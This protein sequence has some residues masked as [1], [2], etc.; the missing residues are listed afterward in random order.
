LPG[1]FF[2]IGVNNNAR[3]IG[4][5]SSSDD[6]NY[7][8]LTTYYL[9][10]KK[11][12]QPMKNRLFIWHRIIAL[13]AAGLFLVGQLN[14]QT[15]TI[16]PSPD[17][18]VESSGFLPASPP[19]IL[20][21]ILYRYY[22]DA[23]YKGRLARFD[24]T[25]ASLVTNPDNGGGF[26]KGQLIVFN[27]AVYGTYYTANRGITI[28]KYDGQQVTL[29]TLPA[30][31]VISSLSSTNDLVVFNN[32]LYALGQTTGQSTVYTYPYYMLKI[33]DG[34]APPPVSGA[35][36]I[37]GV[38]GV[39]CTVTAANQRALTF[40]PRYTGLTGQP[41]T[42]YVTN[43]MQPTTNPGP[44]TLNLYTD[45]PTITLKAS[46]AGSTGE[47]SF[48]YNWLAN[49][50][51]IA[52]SGTEEAGNEL[53][54]TAMPNPSANQSIE[55]ELRGTAGQPVELQLYNEQGKAVSKTQIEQVGDGERIP[56]RLGTTTG[57]YILK[58]S[59]PTRTKSLKL[60]KN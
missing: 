18:P 57:T 15:I 24:G 36:A 19:V 14:A 11:S 12:V 21:G 38:T 45:N 9:S 30:G 46:Q 56:V 54:V 17:T 28:A 40:T 25:T 20:N 55:V 39:S 23:N 33:T 52:R 29:L 53:T 32:G 26:T 48:T 22:L 7:G 58:V 42:F 16:V 50:P 43:E 13:A 51:N 49:C 59:T 34:T 27:N 41:V 6:Y 47:A 4:I 10:P 44:Y 60:L 37:T 5:K 2:V 8:S 1:C 31:I 35:L 3:P